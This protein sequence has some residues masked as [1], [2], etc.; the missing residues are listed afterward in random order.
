MI[1]AGKARVS[2]ICSAANACWAEEK[3]KQQKF[4]SFINS[5][6]IN[7]PSFLPFSQQK[8]QLPPNYWSG[9]KK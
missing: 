6:I 9:S 7:N 4:F 2:T 1:S 3:T 8:R 5:R